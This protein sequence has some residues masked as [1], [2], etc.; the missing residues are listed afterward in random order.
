M[1][2]GFEKS[3][4]KTSE[5]LNSISNIDNVD[6]K[7]K[8][9]VNS[10][11]VDDAIAKLKEL[12]K[13]K[14][15]NINISGGKRA[16]SPTNVIKRTG[17]TGGKKSA[18]K[19]FDVSD[20]LNT[21]S[22]I[23]KTGGKSTAAIGKLATTLGK[24]GPYVA[25]ILAVGAAIG[26][27]AVKG[28]DAFKR[29]QE[30]KA[31]FDNLGKSADIAYNYI[32]K[33]NNADVGNIYSAAKSISQ[34]T[35]G[36]LAKGVGA[37][38]SA[39]MGTQL[40]NLAL[41]IQ[42]SRDFT[43]PIEEIYNN[44]LNAVQQGTD[45][46]VQYGIQ[47]SDRYV[48]A[49]TKNTKGVD[50]FGVEVSDA[51]MQTE[52]FNAVISQGIQYSGQYASKLDTVGGRA[53][54]LKDEITN[55][56][57]DFNRIFKPLLE[58]VLAVITPI[59]QGF[60]DMIEAIADFVDKSE[61]WLSGK[62]FTKST[63]AASGLTDEITK[64][65]EALIKEGELIEK[66]KNALFGFDRLNVL[67]T[68]ENSE[69][70]LD[71]YTGGV[72]GVSNNNNFGVVFPPSGGG[73]GNLPGPNAPATVPVTVPVTVP[74]F[75][76]ATEGAYVF[77]DVLERL[78]I[79]AD[80]LNT[81]LDTLGNKQ[82]SPAFN[83]A[84]LDTAYGRVGAL[85]KALDEIGNKQ[86]SPAFDTVG[87]DAANSKATTFNKTLD[88][89]D[90]KEA[91]PTVETNSIDTAKSKTFDFQSLLKKVD[92]FMANPVVSTA[93]IL[94][95]HTAAYSLI[96]TLAVLA[97]MKIKPDVDSSKTIEASKEAQKANSNMT[98]LLYSATRAW[99][100]ISPKL[101]SLG[102]VMIA[103]GAIGGIGA[104]IAPVGAQIIAALGAATIATGG[105]AATWL[106]TPSGM[107]TGLLGGMSLFSG[108]HAD[109][110]ITTR[111]S[112]GVIGEA[113]S[114][115]V[116]PLQGYRGREALKLIADAANDGDEDAGKVTNYNINI[117]AS[118]IIEDEYTT[119]KF[120][121]KIANNISEVNNS[122]GNIDIGLGV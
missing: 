113:G 71:K 30:L 114:E 4:S 94:T 85:G 66:T 118:N 104:L 10:S 50:L 1:D 21:G 84:G 116:I 45:D 37:S 77:A 69:T 83:T 111:A 8:I 26:Q 75:A 99:D 107:S 6:V 60:G 25:V 121:R 88:T 80:E 119:R 72:D 117:N 47:A 28:Y 110:G 64:Q 108:L 79:R 36:S 67:G 74:D 122:D 82:L 34:F 78:H 55:I 56:G 19:G 70:S 2:K 102:K 3:I 91:S 96:T 5:A 14:K 41:D 43:V 97:G 89:V 65:N 112:L 23:I 68:F 11:D 109:G 53:Q 12:D 13:Y 63:D 9:T 24:F 120:A 29:T 98:S 76:Y 27:L 86:L 51:R 93:G 81:S 42:A 35:T 95:G 49:W 87:I 20:V 100:G 61:N 32:S 16:A 22:K 115:A 17:D 59:V 58:G 38:Q 90:A 31:G 40:Y 103:V 44:L 101:L 18:F 39:E 92:D 52:R 62:G 73:G 7:L 105:A 33:L 54:T 57:S 15:I 46:A 106:T 48:K